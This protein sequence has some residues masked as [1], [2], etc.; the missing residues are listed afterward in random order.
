MA[1]IVVLMI[2]TSCLLG[3][4]FEHGEIGINGFGAVERRGDVNQAVMGVGVSYQAQRYI[5][6]FV[7]VGTAASERRRLLSYPDPD[8]NHWSSLAGIRIPLISN[9]RVEPYVGM[10]AGLEAGRCTDTVT[11]RPYEPVAAALAGARLYLTQGFGLQPEIRL[12]RL[13]RE[14]TLVWRVAVNAFFSFGEPHATA[15]TSRRR[16]ALIAIAILGTSGAAIAVGSIRSR[17]ALGG[18]SAA[19]IAIGGSVFGPPK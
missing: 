18:G 9:A 4:S 12:T 16:R 6:P 10:G 3:Q 8:V 19:G 14:N 7:E 2:L 1:L 11:C 5:V 13:L 17:P 15:T